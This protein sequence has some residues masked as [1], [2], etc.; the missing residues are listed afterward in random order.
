M[1][2]F[3]ESARLL[4][5]ARIAGPMPWVMAIMVA[6]TVI[7]CAA[8]LALANIAAHARSEI[9]GG[10]TVQI[11]EAAPAAR[12][13]QTEAVLARLGARS[14]VIA[15]REVPPEELARLLAPWLGTI[16]DPEES[17]VTPSLIDLQLD[18][19]IDAVFLRALR[20]EIAALAPA[21]R[22]DAQANWL[23]PVFAALRSL[24]WL[25]IGLVALL[26][27]TAAAAVWL[28]ARSALGSNHE[29][30]EVIHHLGGSDNQIANI[31]Q[32]SIALDATIGGLAGLLLGLAAILVLGQQFGALGSGL[33]T[34][35][36]LG[37]GDW[38]LIGAVPLVAVAL[39]VITA[40]VTVLLVLRNIL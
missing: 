23:R 20:A 40:R 19:P 14:D 28:A 3:G 33:V 38:L 22:I 12:A 30:I 24:Q 8:A 35:G 32:R 29:T 36:G 13:R 6:L 9:S 17:L 7:A 16:T 10:L 1:S 27:M 5:Q 34:G 31:F 18:R 2:L 21:A 11:V 39:A 26:T 4:P 25:A 15:M 37:A